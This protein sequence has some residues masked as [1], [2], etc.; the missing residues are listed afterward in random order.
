MAPREDSPYITLGISSTS[1]DVEIKKAY[2]KLALKWH[3]DKHTDDKSKEEAEQK[4]KKIAQAYEILTDK[5]KRADLDRTE[6]P[7]LHRRRSTPGGMHRMHSH[8][9]FRSPFDIFREFFGNRDPFENVFFDDAFTFPDVDSYAFKHPPRSADF[10]TKNHYH[11]FPSSRVHIFYDENK[12]TKER[13]DKNTFSTVIRFSSPTEPGKNA[14]VRK[15]ST[16][17]KLVDGKK[18]VTKTVEN[19]DEHIVEVHEDGEL[20]CR[21]V[22]TPPTSPTV[23]VAAI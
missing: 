18:I 16:S 22:T 9:M 20:K 17:T 6:N 3:P 11:R 14:T 4:F 19:G 23:T 13:D 10:T 2:R 7:G 15:T 5:K 21:T 12:N 8:D 1:D